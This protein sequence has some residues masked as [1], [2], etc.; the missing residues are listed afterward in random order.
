MDELRKQPEEMQTDPKM[1]ATVTAAVLQTLQATGALPNGANKPQSAPDVKNIDLV[2][3]FFAILE[4]FW[5]VAISALVDTLIMGMMAGKGITTYTA[6]SK[7]YI[8]NTSSGSL[9][10][11]NLQVGYKPGKKSS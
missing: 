6:T 11:A 4:K 3:L 8:V 5:L 1:V 9:N 7:L 10:I 2:G